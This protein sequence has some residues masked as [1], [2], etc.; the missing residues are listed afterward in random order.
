MRYRPEIKKIEIQEFSNEMCE[1]GMINC[2]KCLQY[3]V[4]LELYSKDININYILT[5][6]KRI[7]M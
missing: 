3:F 5:K 7:N 4:S 2:F 6:Y 1:I